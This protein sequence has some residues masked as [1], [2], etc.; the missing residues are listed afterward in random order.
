MVNR[1][2]S[3]PKVA[4]ACRFWNKCNFAQ[5]L[6]CWFSNYATEIGVFNS[7]SWINITSIEVFLASRHETHITYIHVVKHRDLRKPHISPL[8]EQTYRL[9]QMT[10][11]ADTCC[12]QRAI[13]HS[14]STLHEKRLD[15]YSIYFSWTDIKLEFSGITFCCLESILCIW[16][17]L[18]LGDWIFRHRLGED[19]WSG[20]QVKGGCPDFGGGKSPLLFVMFLQT[21][22]HSQFV[23]FYT[24]YISYRFFGDAIWIH[25]TI[26]RQGSLRFMMLYHMIAG[27]GKME[28]PNGPTN[29]S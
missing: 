2:V 10:M 27:V 20:N 9:M 8:I 23:E 24:Q 6:L 17:S 19:K 28:V 15:R 11:P 18:S 16:S 4:E 22:G 29:K 25:L 3:F 21:W 5:V 13:I 14:I 26:Y 12:G 1:K 7:W